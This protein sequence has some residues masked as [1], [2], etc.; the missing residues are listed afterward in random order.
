VVVDA[1]EEGSWIY[2]VQYANPL[3]LAG[4]HRGEIWH[5]E[6]ED[7]RPTGSN[8]RVEWFDRRNAS[9]LADSFAEF[10]A[11]L[12]PREDAVASTSP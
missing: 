7:P 4:P 8:P 5:L 11:G 12:R 1:Y 9:K 6:T 3:P 10:I 2:T